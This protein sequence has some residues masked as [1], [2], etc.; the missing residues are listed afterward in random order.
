MVESFNKTIK[1]KKGQMKIQQ[2]SFMLIAVFLFLA[3]VGMIVITVK[4]NELKNS[5]TLLREQNAKLL[6]TK[7]ASSPEFSCGEVY[8]TQKTDCID[9]DKIMVLKESISK[10]TGFWGVSSLEIIKIYPRMPGQIEC[11]RTNYPNCNMITLINKSNSYDKSNFVALCR[12][13]LYKN[14]IVNKCEMGKLIIGYEEA[15]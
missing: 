14:E 7:L 12:K 1:N 10:Y 4:M 3:L 5:A 2:M 11:T 8:G 6:V 13:E 9:L 15:V